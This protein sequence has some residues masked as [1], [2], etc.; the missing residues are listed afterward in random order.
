LR[1]IQ[2]LLN[3]SWVGDSPKYSDPKI[4]AK[5]K[6][7]YGL[8]FCFTSV[9]LQINSQNFCY[10]VLGPNSNTV[11]YTMLKDCGL[12]IPKESGVIGWGPF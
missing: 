3:G 1:F 11:A 2:F 10:D 9:G 6:D 4:V 5:G 12:K 7:A 8:N